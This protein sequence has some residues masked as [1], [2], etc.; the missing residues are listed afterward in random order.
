MGGSWTGTDKPARPVLL[1][2]WRLSWRWS[3]W[4]QYVHYDSVQQFDYNAFKGQTSWSCIVA[5]MTMEIM[6]ML[7]TMNIL[8]RI[9]TARH[10]LFSTCVMLVSKR[11]AKWGGLFCVSHLTIDKV[12]VQWGETFFSARTS[13]CWRICCWV[14]TVMTHS[15]WYSILINLKSGGSRMKSFLNALFSVPSTWN[16][17]GIFW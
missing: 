13:E 5:V 7:V 6:I 14:M 16:R 15:Y 17:D 3:C 8:R 11:P 12:G 1:W 2:S 9:W 4:L 10:R